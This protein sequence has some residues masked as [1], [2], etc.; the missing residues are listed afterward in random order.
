MGEVAIVKDGVVVKT[1]DIVAAESVG[2]ANFLDDIKKIC[3]N[4]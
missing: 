1:V 3:E 2:K 4:W